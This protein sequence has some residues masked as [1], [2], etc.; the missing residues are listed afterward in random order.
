MSAPPARCTV[1]PRLAAGEDGWIVHELEVRRSRFLTVLG[2]V[3]DEAQARAMIAALRRRHHDARHVCSAFVLGPERS[4]ARSS[5]DGEPAGTAGTPMLE[6]LTARETAPGRTDLTDVCAVVVRWFGG[7][8]LGAGGL[9]RAYS[10]S[11]S[12]ALD[13]TPLVTR[14]RRAILAV[15]APHAQAG[16]W[17]NEL[18][19]AGVAVLDAGYGAAGVR[20]RV[21]VPDSDAQRADFAARLADITAGAGRAEP[22]GTEWIDHD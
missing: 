22:I 1:L 8:K 14:S 10:E 12:A 20:L 3:A 15:D 11:V 13:T 17:E 9:V 16:R 21:G 18:R 19:A 5:D 7:V 4:V 2:R 6:A